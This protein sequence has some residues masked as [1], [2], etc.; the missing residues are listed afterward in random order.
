MR[1]KYVAEPTFQTHIHTRPLCLYKTNEAPQ[2][3]AVSYLIG[4][5]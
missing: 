3:V 1:S 5:K 4:W 2:E